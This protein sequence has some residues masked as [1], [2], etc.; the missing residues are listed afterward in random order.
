MGRPPPHCPGSLSVL[1]GDSASLWSVLSP[2]CQAS[3][4]RV[5]HRAPLCNGPF[6]RACRPAGVE[7]H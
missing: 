6:A 1:A 4:V 2:E 7:L 3:L 5:T